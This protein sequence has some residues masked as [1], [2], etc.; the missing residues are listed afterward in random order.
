[1]SRQL[2]RAARKSVLL[3]HIFASVGWMG[4][5]L[6][7]FA[8]VLTGLTTSSGTLA[9]SCFLALTVAVPLGVGALSLLMVG[10]G[11]LLGL[12]TKWG[13]V[14]YWW[15]ASKLAIGLLLVTLVYVALIPGVGELAATPV[16]A[17]GDAVRAVIGS[18]A[19]SLLY[20]PIVSFSLL[21][22]SAVLSVF[23]PWGRLRKAAQT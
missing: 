18:S 23:K 22:F 7:F 1:M 19:Q 21:G 2:P 3:L 12:G 15:V 9:A 6:A 14:R 16:A 5:D 20:P 11:V 4:M 10:T 17:T 8:L 13:L